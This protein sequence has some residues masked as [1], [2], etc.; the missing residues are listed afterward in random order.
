MWSR[1]DSF[2]EYVRFEKLTYILII[3]IRHTVSQQTANYYNLRYKNRSK[4][5]FFPHRKVI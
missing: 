1:F 3:F 2:A 5:A 4:Q